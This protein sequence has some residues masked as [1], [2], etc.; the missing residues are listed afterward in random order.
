MQRKPKARKGSATM[1][2]K[3]KERG[4]HTS[5]LNIS[6][7]LHLFILGH[8]LMTHSTS[9]KHSSSPL[10]N[11]AH[12]TAWFEAKQFRYSKEASRIAFRHIHR[13]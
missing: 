5:L 8:A 10:V 2:T 4:L 3:G 1:A 7:L 6:Q 13:V 11:G 9:P 12:S